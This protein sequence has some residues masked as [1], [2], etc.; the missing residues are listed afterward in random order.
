M[1]K[2]SIYKPGRA[3][4]KT[5]GKNSQSTKVKGQI[6]STGNSVFALTVFQIT[7]IDKALEKY[8]LQNR[9]PYACARY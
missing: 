6:Q 2:Q 8:N 9:E 7:L 5:G 4:Y 1:Q 3:I